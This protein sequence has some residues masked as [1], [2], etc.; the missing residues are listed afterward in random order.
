MHYAYEHTK[1]QT[2]G[3]DSDSA[4]E[5]NSSYS[6]AT[7]KGFDHVISELQE[8][9]GAGAAEDEANLEDYIFSFFVS[10]QICVRALV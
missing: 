10:C 9:P 7:S 1:F 8:E 6:T 3:Q 4:A 2:T 5:A